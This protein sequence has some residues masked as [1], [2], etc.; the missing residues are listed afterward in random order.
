[1]AV[2]AAA[3]VAGWGRANRVAA[4]VASGVMAA[5]VAAARVV[6]VTAVAVVWGEGPAAVGSTLPAVREAAAERAAAAAWAAPA[7]WEG[8]AVARVAGS[9][10]YSRGGRR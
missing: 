10:S 1:M 6:A 9:R 7:A 8:L 2:M 4:P 5:Q 3:A